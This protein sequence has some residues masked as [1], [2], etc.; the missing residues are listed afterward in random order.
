MRARVSGKRAQEERQLGKSRQRAVCLTHSVPIRVTFARLCRETR[1]RLR[2]TQQQLAEKVGVTR[3]YI[4]NIERGAANPSL[5]QVERIAFALDLELDFFARPPLVIGSGQQHDLVHA[6]C[7]AYVDRRLRTAGW[8]TAREVEVV[9]ARSHGWIDLLAFDPRSG[10]LLIVE[11]KTRLDDIGAVERQLGWYERSAFMVAS[12][13]GWHPRQ[14]AS[15]LLVLASDQ[16]ETVIHQNRELL[17]RVFPVRARE[18][19]AGLVP[20]EHMT[21]RRGVAL[22]D[23]VSRRR[24]WLMRSR[25]DGRRSPAPYVDYADAA[26]RLGR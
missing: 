5:D 21:S 12:G 9:H 4:A 19:A 26:R 3:G 2:L 8:Q 6:R 22:I 7:S 11:V 20:G 15:W 10:T 24:A 14:V 16:V 23:P 1:T 13:L 17:A 18:M 25:T